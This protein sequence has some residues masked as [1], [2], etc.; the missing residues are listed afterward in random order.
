MRF[1]SYVSGSLL[2]L[3]ERIVYVP[4]E[5]EEESLLY[6]YASPDDELIMFH[7]TETMSSTKMNIPKPP[8]LP[9]PRITYQRPQASS[10]RNPS[11]SSSRLVPKETVA[12]WEKVFIDGTGGDTN[13]HTEDN[14][15]LLAHSSILVR[16]CHNMKQCA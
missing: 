14:F 16:S 2:H 1:D 4:Y 13:V 7:S 6:I 3:I 9:L 12:T 5:K 10:T 15:Y 8:P 11:S